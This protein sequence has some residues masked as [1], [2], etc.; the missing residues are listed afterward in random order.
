MLLIGDAVHQFYS[1]SVGRLVDN[2]YYVDGKP[3]SLTQ[4]G[5]ARDLTFSVE[6]QSETKNHLHCN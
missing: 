3:Y 2:T 4:H 5:F 1:Q 6:E